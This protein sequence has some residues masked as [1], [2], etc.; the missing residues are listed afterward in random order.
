MILTTFYDSSTPVRRSRQKGRKWAAVLWRLGFVFVICAAGCQPLPPGSLSAVQN[1]G[2]RGPI[3]RV[4][5]IRGWRDLWSRGIDELAAKLE[6]RGI[7]ATVF[8]AEQWR[9]LSAALRTRYQAAAHAPL[10][11]IGFSYGADDV[12]RV[13]EELE[14]SG[15]AVDLAVTIDP[16]TP[17]PVPTNV[18]RCYNLFQTNGVWDV[19]PWLRGIPLRQRV[20]GSGALINVDIRKDRPDLLE[21]D[22]SH[23][24]IAANAKVHHEI[25]MQALTVLGRQ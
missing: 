22:T 24:N 2:P 12:L 11:L 19:F 1:V 14:R 25:M 16:V 6:R 3:D 13:A 8:R 18:R 21:P 9:D 17:P 4:Y 23:A 10:I 7:E 20:V 5:L 15:V